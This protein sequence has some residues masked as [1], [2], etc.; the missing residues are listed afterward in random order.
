MKVPLLDLQLQQRAVQADVERAV[1]G[2]F[3]SAGFVLGPRVAECEEA[4]ARYCGCRHGVG[5]SSGTD[6]L[7]VCLMA[8]GIGPGHE[9][10]TTA[11]SFFATAGAVA[12]V[13]ATPVFVDIDPVTF[14]L[15]P[16]Q[17]AARITSKTKAIIPVHLYGQMAEMGPLMALA[18]RHNLVVIE[19]ACQAVGPCRTGERPVR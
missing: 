1:A 13:G 4:V 11:Y 9:V 10:I 3:A 5:V 18:E 6:A 8:E 2:I 19:D 14:N 7:L 12:R 15:L 17:V 16:D